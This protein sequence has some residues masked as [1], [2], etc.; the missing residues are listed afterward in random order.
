MG[1]GVTLVLD[2]STGIWHEWSTLTIGSSVSVS[3]ITR[4][5]TTATVTCATA[6]GISDGDPVTIAGATQ[7]DYN[8]TFQAAYVS[9]TVFAIE[10]ENSPAT[11]ATGTILAYPYSSSYFK[12]T[13]YASAN[14][15]D[16]TLHATD[17]HL[18]EIDPDTYQDD[19]VPIDFFVR[20][21][22]LDG[23]SIRRKKI[24]RIS[25]VGESADDSAM[26][27]FSDDDSATFVSYRR[28]TLS[29]AEPNI[30]RCGAFER[31]SLEFRHVGNTSPRLEALELLIGE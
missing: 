4:D 24:A 10:V 13:H 1:S 23:G 3:S 30:R 14:G 20:T 11:P 6:H 7:T 16:V 19:G 17:G 8:G 31:R 9:A 2:A 5:G 21:S 27:R 12:L 18:Y 25:V 15:V 29:D 28:V 22:R 26:L